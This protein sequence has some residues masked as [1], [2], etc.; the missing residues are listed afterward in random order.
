[1]DRHLKKIAD[2]FDEKGRRWTDVYQKKT[3]SWHEYHPLKIRENRALSLIRE[4]RLGTAI[5]LGCGCGSALVKMKRMGFKRV[6]GVDIS[7]G[8]LEKSREL[9]GSNG[10]SGQIELY[11]AD[12]Q[13]LKDVESGSVDACIALGVIEYLKSDHPLL[14]EINRILKQNGVAVIQMRNYDCIH[15]RA[16]GLINRL[17]SVPGSKIWYREH[18]VKEFRYSARACGLTIKREQY[19]HFYALFPIDLIPFC[20]YRLLRFE[21]FLNKKLEILAESWPARWL[22]SMYIAKV[23]KD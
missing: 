20:K 6:I 12:V 21:N 9:A 19:S 1:L 3:E 18:K 14:K 2:F 15:S 22:A 7:D 11:K 4:A 23:Q 8:M 10:L 17:F 5:D 16:A 13:D